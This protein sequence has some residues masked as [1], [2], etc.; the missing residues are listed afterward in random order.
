MMHPFFSAARNSTRVAS[1]RSMLTRSFVSKP[2]FVNTRIM[3]TG[4]MMPK[5]KLF[6]G[7]VGAFYLANK[8]QSRSTILNDAV[9][10]GNRGITTQPPVVQE[11]KVIKSRF[12]GK[13]DYQELT[14]GSITGLFL[15]ILAGKLSS[16]IVFL[17]LSGYL[18]TQFLENRGIITIPWR[19]FVNIGSEKIDV[20]R[21]V[22]NQPSF[23]IS[24][25]L[26]FLIAAF[27]V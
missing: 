15:G 13:L 6:V 27:N 21:L 18:L 5:M 3:S 22:L 26:T 10:A 8:L 24:F 9:F 19:Q 23:K 14:I 4:T 16:A 20:K 12:G 1:M 11:Q 25:V 7:S 17:T 2:Q